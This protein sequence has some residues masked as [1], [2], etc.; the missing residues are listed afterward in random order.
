MN[1]CAEA[2][3][4]E[5]PDIVIA[6][7]QSDEYSFVLRRDSQLFRRRSSKILSNVVSLV[8]SS[9][10]FLWPRFFGDVPLQYAPVFDSRVVCYPTNQ[11]LRDYL[12]W[13]QA[14][15]HIN[16][17]FNTCFWNL[18]QKGGLTEA[19]AEQRLSGT[20]SSDKNELLFTE[21]G[22]NYNNVDAMYRR[23]SIVLR[24]VVA[25]TAA[26]PDSGTNRKK[27][28]RRITVLHRDLIGDEF[29]TLYPHILDSKE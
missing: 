3:L 24:A 29:W 9:Y 27:P 13:R 23:G 10:V 21:F 12:S 22:L 8:S 16:N 5:Y 19:E 17:L 7:G 25:D 18:V 28:K 6:F 15:C 20:V 14:D 2:V 1:A 11:N 26:R 4:R